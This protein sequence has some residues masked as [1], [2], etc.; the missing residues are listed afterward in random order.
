MIQLVR[1][2]ENPI[3]VPTDLYWENFLVFNTAA[4]I[5]DGK[6]YLIYRAQGTSDSVSRFGL[7]TSTDGITFE[8]RKDP[9][10]QSS[11]HSYD[12]FGAEDPR[13]VKIDDN[14]YL[15]YTVTAE[16]K[17]QKPNPIWKEQI[18]KKPS[19]A[20]SVTKDFSNYTDFGPI[21]PGQKNASF[22][23]K[24]INGEYWLMFR[25]E[26]GVTQ[27]T[28][29]HKI[30][31]WPNRHPLFTYRPG[32][33]D[34]IRVG[35]GSQPIETEKGWLLFYHGVDEKNVYR[36]GIIFLDLEDP[37]KILYRSP[38]PIFEP[39]TDYEKFGFIKDVVFTCGAVEKDDKYYVY[40]GACDEVIGLATVEKK[41]V[42][43][44][45]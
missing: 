26:H 34:A 30:R 14:Y 13:I 32:F 6:I 9:I 45:F 11:G 41:L 23:P 8:R 15:V 10:F 17:T 21:L 2:K 40:Y 39:T 37:R 16:D 22:F 24:K 31:D 3:L 20:L 44:L 43:N 28:H 18:V 19:I 4:T 25:D 5:F 29:S 27:I 12:T 36:L 35:I 33:W 38:E 7:A 42:L 1:A